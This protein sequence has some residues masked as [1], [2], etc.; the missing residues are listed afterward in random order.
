MYPLTRLVFGSEVR[1]VV[2]F[3]GSRDASEDEVL[4]P[5]SFGSIDKVLALDHFSLLAG[6]KVSD[7]ESSVDSLECSLETSR[8]AQIALMRSGSSFCELAC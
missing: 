1:Y 7:Q 3:I 2:G 4:N 6:L 5:G 8:V